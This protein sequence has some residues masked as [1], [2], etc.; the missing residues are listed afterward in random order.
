MA[1]QS[2]ETG[3]VLLRCY[4]GLLLSSSTSSVMADGSAAVKVSGQDF[5]KWALRKTCKL[6]Q[7]GESQALNY[8]KKQK[9]KHKTLRMA[10]MSFKGTFHPKLIFLPTYLKNSGLVFPLVGQ[11]SGHRLRW[12]V[13]KW[14]RT[15]LSSAHPRWRA[16]GLEAKD[17]TTCQ[18][19]RFDSDQNRLFLTVSFPSVELQNS[20][21]D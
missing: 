3:W 19:C 20:Y 21:T 4:C 17:G 12:H 7:T 6:S 9:K 13:R 5:L 15:S 18:N 8:L 2:Y 10:R 14:K 11:W 16:P 1:V